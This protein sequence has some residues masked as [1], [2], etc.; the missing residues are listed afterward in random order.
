[1]KWVVVAIYDAKAESYGLPH[2]VRTTEMAV[3]NFEAAVRHEGSDFNRFPDDYS[4][5]QVGVFDD[6]TGGIDPVMPQCLMTGTVLRTR[7]QK[8]N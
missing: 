4:V 5:H 3:R 1:M 6:E 7:A 2:T 8:E